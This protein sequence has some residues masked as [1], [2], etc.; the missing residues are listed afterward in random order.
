MQTVRYYITPI[1]LA[2]IVTLIAAIGSELQLGLR[3]DRE[4]ILDGQ[5]WRLISAHLAHL[6][7]SHLFMNLLGLGLI[8]ALFGAHYPNRV[9]ILAF[10]LGSLGVS[11]MLLWLNPELHWYVGLSGVLHTFFILGCLADIEK[12]RWGGTGLLLAVCAKLAYEQFSGPLPGSEASAGGKVIVD[13]HLYG[14]IWGGVVY[15]GVY[16]WGKLRERFFGGG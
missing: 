8:W 13:S 2:L 5:W 6:G 10:L 11:A 7:W 15:L 12:S 3:Y 16:L 4:A 14:A 1:T 9:W